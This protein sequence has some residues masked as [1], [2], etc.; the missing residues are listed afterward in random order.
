MLTP[1]QRDEMAEISRRYPSSLM[2]AALADRAEIAQEL[3]RI[4][5]SLWEEGRS[6]YEAKALTALI[7]RIK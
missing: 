6:H 2:A 4:A 7:E 5:Q 1:E 3:E